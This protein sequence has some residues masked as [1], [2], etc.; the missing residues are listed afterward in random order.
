MPGPSTPDDDEH[1]GGKPNGGEPIVS[2]GKPVQLENVVSEQFYYMG[3]YLIANGISWQSTVLRK[4]V[5][6]VLN[7]LENW[8]PVKAR[9]VQIPL[10]PPFP[11]NIK[12]V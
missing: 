8:T 11:D 5:D 7:D 9:I 1:Y 2:I 4:S 3:F 6:E 10:P 12:F